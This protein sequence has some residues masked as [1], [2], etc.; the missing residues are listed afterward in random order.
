MITGGRRLLAAC[1]SAKRSARLFRLIDTGGGV[2]ELEVGTSDG[3]DRETVAV[4]F[5]SSE[6]DGCRRGSGGGRVTT[7]VFFVVVANT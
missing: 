6:R 4:E 1:A 5:F 3:G 2:T 7:G